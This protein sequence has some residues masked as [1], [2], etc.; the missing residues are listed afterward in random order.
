MEYQHIN[1]YLELTIN[2]RFN[3]YT[4]EDL[5]NHFHLSKK[6]IHS[7]RMSHD[8]YLNEQLVTQNFIISLK[9]NDKL[10]IPIFVDE[11]IDFNKLFHNRE[12]NSRYICFYKKR[13]D[14]YKYYG[15]SDVIFAIVKIYYIPS[16]RRWSG[17]LCLWRGKTNDLC[18][19]LRKHKRNS[20]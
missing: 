15:Y 1:Q 11:E 6:M 7:L 13:K 2:N 17:F 19:R 18:K 8:V 10:K 12:D 3:N 9:Q 5:F 4:I 20:M 14:Y 16:L